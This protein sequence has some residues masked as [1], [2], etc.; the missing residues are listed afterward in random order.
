MLETISEIL[1][2]CGSANSVL[3]PTELY[4]E[5]WMLCLVL[6]WFD[7]NRELSHALSFTSGA[8]WYIEALLPSAFL[9]K[10][11]GD[12]RAESFTHADGMIGHFSVASGER[13]EA[14]LL[15]G[16]KQLVIIEAKLGSTLSTGT[17]NVPTYDQAARNVA[18]IAYMLG[19]ADVDPRSLERLAFYVLAP[20]KQINA[21][22]FGDL[23]TTDS[24]EQ[25][26][27]DRVSAYDGTL[28]KWFNEKFR[29]CLKEIELG[30]LSWEKVLAI[31]PNTTET[32]R[33]HEFYAQC[34]KF[35]PL[36]VRDAV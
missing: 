36:R 18:C 33:L 3:P 22:V 29:P 15:P 31:L 19:A 25:K 30:I 17:K 8:K 7:Q 10:T 20:E 27:R 26:V 2:R 12:A 9:P 13:G 6:N 5:G 35:N 16:V 24:I 11:R 28:D 14:K 4:N 23:V 21:G 32:Q 34:L 1:G